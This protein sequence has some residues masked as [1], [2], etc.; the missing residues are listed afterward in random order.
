MN[1]TVR[2]LRDV[3]SSR[4]D[5]GEDFERLRNISTKKTSPLLNKLQEHI[6]ALTIAYRGEEG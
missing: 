3:L 2:E 1:G 4:K 6:T 5:K